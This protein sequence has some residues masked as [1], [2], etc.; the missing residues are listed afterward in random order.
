MTTQPYRPAEIV[1]PYLL[2]LGDIEDSVSAKMARAVVI[3]RPEK[4]VGQ[5]RMTEQTVS[6]G[7]EDLS[8]ED[9]VARGAKTLVIGVANSGG[10]LPAHWRDVICRAIEHGMD[11]ASGMHQ[12]LDA[13]EGVAEL[14]RE[15]GVTLHDI[16]HRHPPLEVGTGEPRSGRRILTVGTDCSLGKMFSSLALQ[17]GLEEAGHKARFRATGQCG[18]L[19]AGDGVAIDAVIAD[20]ISG[21][22]EWLSPAGPEDQWDIIEGQGSLFHPAYAGV[23]L[24]LLHGAQPDYL[25]MCHELGRPHMRHLPH[26]P[27]PDM[28]ACIEA[29][30][31]AA[32]VTN[33]K[34]QLAGFAINTSQVDEATARRELEALSQQF[35][36]PATDPVR[37]GVAPLVNALVQGD[38]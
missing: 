24:G 20:F 7:I 14:A 37:F 4:A 16:R 29:N 22:V 17:R 15:H 33:P 25:I 5:L 3:W 2:F 6:V 12:R 32:R 38:A 27:M 28:A 34:V 1:A 31:S 10:K 30:L 36:V 9:A 13:I 23:S 35:G 21:A 19:V 18:V 11:V 8:I 26:R